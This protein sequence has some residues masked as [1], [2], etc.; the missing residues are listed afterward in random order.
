MSFSLLS[1]RQISKHLELKTEYYKMIYELAVVGET[2][3]ERFA[4]KLASLDW[5][6]KML[7]LNPC[8]CLALECRDG[9][10]KTVDDWAICGIK[11]VFAAIA[12]EKMKGPA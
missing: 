4:K 10:W 11:E 1:V 8:L 5:E 12:L 6:V 7:L 9:V 3:N 2:K